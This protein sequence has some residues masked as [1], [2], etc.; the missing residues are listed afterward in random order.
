MFKMVSSVLLKLL[1]HITTLAY[2][3]YRS[4]QS[5]FNPKS[6]FWQYMV[7]SCA[8]CYIYANAIGFPFSV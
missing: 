7:T 3:G 2:S 5:P 1:L 4:G 6:V 8:Q